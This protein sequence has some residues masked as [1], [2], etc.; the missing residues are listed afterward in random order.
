MRRKFKTEEHHRRSRFTGGNDSP[1]NISYVLP[2]LHRQWHVLFGCMNA[3]QI[4]N[5]I[6]KSNFKPKNVLLVCDFINGSEVEKN[7]GQESKNPN[8]RKYA[9]ETLFSECVNFQ[10]IISYINHT[11]LD[12]SYRLR[13]LQAE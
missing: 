11:W 3:F 4:C 5:N 8:K 12:P 7:G 2:E 6:N 1:G 13:I 10:E 9:W